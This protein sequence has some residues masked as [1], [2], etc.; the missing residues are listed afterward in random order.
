M[1]GLF[2]KKNTAENDA[3]KQAEPKQIIKIAMIIGITGTDGAGK[4][5]V[6]EYL[7]K[8]HDFIHCSARDLLTAEVKQRGLEAS[9]DNLRLVAND[10]RRQHGH[11]FIVKTALKKIAADG[12]AKAVIESIRTTAEAETLKSNGGILVAVDADLKLRYERIKKRR[13]DSDHISLAEFK[14]QEA[15]EMNDPDPNGM[16]KVVVMKIADHTIMNNSSY[17]ALHEAT[18]RVLRQ[19]TS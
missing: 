9:R 14:R 19:L 16:Q 3:A 1:S 6:V 10:L 17:F 18:E 11:D 5:E 13:L 12:I 7:V 2:K 8:R 15:L 4:G